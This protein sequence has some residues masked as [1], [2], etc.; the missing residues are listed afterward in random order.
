MEQLKITE[1]L[2]DSFNI[3][4]IGKHNV[5]VDEVEKALADPNRVFMETYKGRLLGLGRSEKRL[6][7]TVLAVDKTTGSYYVVTARDMDK[8]E[9][10]IYRKEQDEKSRNQ[11]T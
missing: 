9:R 10:Q 6:I 8:K 2:W 4:H 5:T 3:E 11:N 7:A 1:L